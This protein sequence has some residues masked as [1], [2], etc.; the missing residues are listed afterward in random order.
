MLNVASDFLEVKEG[1]GFFAKDVLD[2]RAD[3]FAFCREE[4]DGIIYA[5]KHPSKYLFGCVPYA[6]PSQEFF[7]GN[8][9][10]ALMLGNFW[11]VRM[12]CM[13]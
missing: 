5:V 10:F 11:M 9:I 8:R 1:A 4:L 7:L 12:E 3:F 13:P 6:I 2:K